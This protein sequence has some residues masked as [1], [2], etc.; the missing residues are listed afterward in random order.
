VL[1]AEIKIQ[2]EGREIPPITP[3]GDEGVCL[4]I[5]IHVASVQYLRVF[6]RNDAPG[7]FGRTADIPEQLLDGRIEC[8]HLPFAR[9]QRHE[10]YFPDRPH[11]G[12]CIG[13]EVSDV[14][15]LRAGVQDGPIIEDLIRYVEFFVIDEEERLVV[16]PFEA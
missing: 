16:A 10:V 2:A 4:G 9:C 11:T 7:A 13:D 1:A 14:A 3:L 5:R 15:L 6:D 8:G 12:R